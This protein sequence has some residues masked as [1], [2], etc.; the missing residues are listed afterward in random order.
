[1]SEYR[2]ELKFVLSEIEYNEVKLFL[3]RHRFQNSYPN[4]LI[5]SLYFDSIELDSVGEN[6]S[7]ISNRKKIRLRWYGDSGANPELE[8]KKRNGRVGNK[9]KFKIDSLS[10]KDLHFLSPKEIQ[11]KTF[12]FIKENNNNFVLDKYY[13]PIIH[14]DYKRDY[15]ESF[16]KVRLTIDKEINFKPISLYKSISNTKKISHNKIV[17]ELKFNP[18]MTDY[19]SNLIRKL[20]LIPQR[21][22]KYLFG[23]SRLGYAVYI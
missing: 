8:I 18:K 20:N 3:I 12:T 9:T 21:H 17:M 10:S 4:R 19:V 2:Y 15:Y 23:V 13:S 5:N 6:L 1:M 7:G 22:S 14:I 16:N 11:H